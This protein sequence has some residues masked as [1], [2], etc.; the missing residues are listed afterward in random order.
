METENEKNETFVSTDKLDRKWIDVN[1]PC[2]AACPAM[3]DIPGYIQT[4]AAGD[5][6]TAYRIN[7][8]ENI[9]PGV[10][11]RDFQTRYIHLETPLLSP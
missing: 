6:E 10:L 1:I 3:T 11:G 5:Y 2:S 9:L 8:E 7:R 4:I